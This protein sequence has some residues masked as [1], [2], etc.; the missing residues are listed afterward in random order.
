[1]VNAH[2]DPEFFCQ[3]GMGGGGGGGVQAQPRENSLD[4]LYVCFWVLLVQNFP[5]MQGV[6]LNTGGGGPNANF[7]RI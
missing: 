2:A 1:M 7:Y 3:R 5:R 6:Q 4:F